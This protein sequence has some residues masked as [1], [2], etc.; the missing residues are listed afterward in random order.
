MRLPTTSRFLGVVL[1]A[2]ALSSA[3]CGASHPS[4]AD[5][6]ADAG[7]EVCTIPDTT[8]PVDLPLAG[9]AC[10]TAEAC[11]YP[12]PGGTWMWTYHC[13]DLAWAGTS[14]CVPA[15]GGSCPVGP[16]AES[17]RAPFAGTLSGA[18]IEIGGPGTGPFHP[19]LPG[20]LVTLI[21]G[22]QGAPML[23]FRVRV[24]GASVPICVSATISLTIDGR[25]PS[26]EERSLTLHCGTTLP[27]FQIVADPCDGAMHT[28]DVHVDVAGIGTTHVAVE[29]LGPPCVD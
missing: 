15:P 22:G 8:C 6:G 14:D 28:L 23:G 17:C 2:T 21:T 26:T 9:A 27:A 11:T 19:L 25:P 12:D 18:T 7:P 4:V 16:L 5:G 13:A 20:E 3:G 10:D 24:S 1:T 29:Y